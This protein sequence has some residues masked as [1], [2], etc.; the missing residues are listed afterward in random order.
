MSRSRTVDLRWIALFNEFRRS[1]L[2]QAEFCRRQGISLHTF[3][4][5]LY[6]PRQAKPVPTDHRSPASPSQAFL[7]VTILPD[8]APTSN[9]PHQPLELILPNGRRIAVAPGFDSQT[10]RRL[11]AV[12]EQHPCSD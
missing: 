2:T 6:Q 7:P 4:K 10:L 12:L 1:G 9:H 5:R 3:R 11:V 8:P